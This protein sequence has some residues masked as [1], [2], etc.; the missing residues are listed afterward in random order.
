MHRPR[1]SILIH[2]QKG[3]D[4]RKQ[5]LR[6]FFLNKVSGTGNDFVGLT[7]RARNLVLKTLLGAARNANHPAAFQFSYLRDSM[8]DSA[9]CG[10]DNHGFTGPELADIQQAKVGGKPGPAGDI[11]LAPLLLHQ[12]FT[13]AT[14][15]DAVDTLPTL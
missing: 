5:F 2:I 12:R 10:R 3:N 1:F 14:R 7:F 11:I 8:P 6:L 9:R 13:T 4:F 15:Q